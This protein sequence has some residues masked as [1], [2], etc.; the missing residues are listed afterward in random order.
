MICPL[1]S[2]TERKVTEFCQCYE[3][4][5]AW[6]IKTGEASGSCAIRQ[7]AMQLRKVKQDEP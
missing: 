7:I 4:E 1:R 6:W 2:E 5:C 3:E